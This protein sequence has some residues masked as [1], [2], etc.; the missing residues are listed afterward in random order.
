[1]KNNT[2]ALDSSLRGSEQKP[3]GQKVWVLEPEAVM[4]E[5]A[6]ASGGVE[7]RFTADWLG[8]PLADPWLL[9]SLGLFMVRGAIFGLFILTGG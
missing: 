7:Q 8:L 6:G 4:M 3:G 2:L 1:M 9:I 5:T